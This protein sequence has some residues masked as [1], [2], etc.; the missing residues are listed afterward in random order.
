MAAATL[1]AAFL[2]FF[3]LGRQSLWIDEAVMWY[4]T[5][6]GTPLTLAGLLEKTHGPLHA[7]V[8]QAWCAI[9]GD[10]EWALRAPSAVA[11]VLVVPAMAWLAALW[12]GLKAA[13]AAA[14]LTAGSPFLVWYSQEARSYSMLTLFVALSSAALLALAR[15]PRPRAALA[16]AATSAAGLLSS[17]S[18]ALVGPVHVRWWLGGP[19]ARG[20]RV[21]GLAIGG[22]LVAV[23][24]LPWVPR[25]V[26]TLDWSRLV[27]GRVAQAGETP[28]RGG[29]TFH[30]GA[31]PFT[32]HAF[33]VGYS[34]GPPL[35]ELRTE[36]VALVLARH[37]V[38]LGAV[39]VVFGTLFVIGLE[40]LR[41]RGRL[42]DAALWLLVPALVVS[43][44][45]L[46]NFKTFHPRY[47]MV[48]Y[49]AF[50]LT[51]AAA[52][53]ALPRWPRAVAAAALGA[54]WLLAL[55]HH[56][57][58]PRYAKE[59]YRAAGALVRERGVPGEQ[60]IAVH[61]DEAMRYYYRGPLPQRT[62]WLGFA[63]RRERLEYELDRALEASRGAWVVLSRH[64][65]LDPRDEFARTLDSRYPDAERFP[66][67]GVRVWHIRRS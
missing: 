17:F 25:I 21:K 9:A 31:V 36:P 12:L 56:Y 16:Y 44:F 19:A 45:A 65:D 67:T 22:V 1:V 7:A 20:R 41:R 66:L 62:V 46:Q 29:T 18:Y 34:F 63:G 13:P 52:L 57:F 4:S 15:A 60:V 61:S 5:G 35:R 37:A 28:L 27:P 6:V 64:E 55:H 14:W 58:D 50:L 47:L 33:A 42:G 32:F 43:Y 49:P 10:S 2:R 39:A 54:V 11:G 51:L 3:H 53:A 8:L 23:L 40:A 48:A 59:D 24:A 30:P 38:A 26:H